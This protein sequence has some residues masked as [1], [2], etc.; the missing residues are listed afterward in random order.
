MRIA[1]AWTNPK[2]V[3]FFHS[4]YH[5]STRMMMNFDLSKN[6]VLQLG[7][8]V[9]IESVR[10]D[11]CLGL[12]TSAYGENLEMGRRKISE[13]NGKPVGWIPGVLADE[14]VKKVTKKGS[15]RSNNSLRKKYEKKSNIRG[16]ASSIREWSS[17]L[18]IRQAGHGDLLDREKSWRIFCLDKTFLLVWVLKFLSIYLQTQ[19]HTSTISFQKLFHALTIFL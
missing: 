11:N 9:K 16:M 4:K 8:S 13:K 10:F 12:Q 14:S 5:P 15:I 1:T 6:R 7:A 3:F 19:T 2:L 17:G 18:M